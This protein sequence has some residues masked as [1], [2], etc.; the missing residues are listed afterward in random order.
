MSRGISLHIGLNRVD[1]SQYP[2]YTIPDLSGCINDANSMRDIAVQCGFSTTDQLLDG[3]ATAMNVLQKINEA[4]SQLCSGDIFLLTYSG[5]GSQVPDETGEEEDGMNETWV[6]YDRQLIDN[7]LYTCWQKFAAGVRIFVSS[8]S[9]HS[10]SMVRMLLLNYMNENNPGKRAIRKAFSESDIVQFSKRLEAHP[11]RSLLVGPARKSIPIAA[12]LQNYVKNKALYQ[13]I[14]FLTRNAKAAN[15]FPASLIYISGCQ[16]NQLSGDGATNGVF[17]GRLLTV[18]NN[19]A[20]NGHYKTFYDN[21]IADMPSDQT[22]NYM[23]LG[24]NLAS[25][26]AQKPFTIL[27]SSAGSGTSNNN[28]P[29]AL[30][31][32]Q[33]PVSWNADCLPPCFNVDRAGNPQYYVEFATDN[34]LFDAANHENERTAGN[35]YASYSDE[36]NSYALENGNTYTMKAYTWEAMKNSPIIYF[37]IGSTI[38]YNW[39][40]WK[41]SFNDSDYA[42]APSMQVIPGGEVPVAGGSVSNGA[43][44]G[45]TGGAG[46]GTSG[47]SETSSSRIIQSVGSGGSN[48]SGDVR[49]VQQ[50]LSQ[51]PAAEGG[52]PNIQIDGIC[53]A[54][55]IAAIKKFQT[56][57]E[58]AASGLFRPDKGSVILL[59]IKSGVASYSM[60]MMEELEY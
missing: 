18:W 11:S 17:T 8:D 30:P 25:F 27:G 48:Q 16:D 34:K 42:S 3:Q 47:E 51:V 6:L 19:G 60:R 55:T 4:S 43:V 49:L 58:C 13:N 53:G 24:S 36:Q 10:G 54:G 22:P 38:D 29:S 28:A 9:C 14:Q 20:F 7:E 26:E 52:T 12:S 40:G 59:Y 31:S 15:E 1:I 37:R 35:F 23:T 41:V 33:A 46:T 44:S 21:I 32:M 5:H 56:A 2:G 39:N 50:L 45:G 57:N